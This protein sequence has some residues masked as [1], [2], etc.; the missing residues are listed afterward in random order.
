MSNPNVPTPL[1]K[2]KTAA[3]GIVKFASLKIGEIKTLPPNSE[4]TVENIGTDRDAILVFGIP[5]GRTGLG[6]NWKGEAASYDQL[7]ADAKEGDTYYIPS[8][9]LDIPGKIYVCQNGSFPAN[10]E[11]I[12]FQGPRGK[13]GAKG[14]AATIEIGKVETGAAGSNATVKNVGST[15]AAKLDIVI[16]RGDQGNEGKAATIKIGTVATGAPG[17]TASVTNSGNNNAVVLDFV[18]PQGMPLSLI[19]I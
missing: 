15:N 13:T 18:L 17:S 2:I 9:N 16:P 4:A 5:E 7:P 19:H 8:S 12:V 1:I 3:G 11:G 14:T 6:I 10:G